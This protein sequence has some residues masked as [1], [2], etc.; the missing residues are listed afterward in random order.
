MAEEKDPLEIFMQPEVTTEA[1][2][3]SHSMAVRPRMKD[4]KEADLRERSTISRVPGCD[5]RWV[6]PCYD[7][8]ESMTPEPLTK[9]EIYDL[10]FFFGVTEAEWIAL[11]TRDIP[12]P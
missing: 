9:R 8:H 10:Q 6:V 1:D 11:Y 3:A 2:A 4:S 7:N 5:V 12:L